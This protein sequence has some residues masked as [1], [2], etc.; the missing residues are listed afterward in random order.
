MIRA[1]SI[2]VLL[3]VAIAPESAGESLNDLSGPTPITISAQALDGFDRADRSRR[4]FGE[5]RFRGGI[6]LSSSH[7][8]FGGLSGFRIQED[9]STFIALSDR[10]V[11]LRGRI[12]YQLGRPAGIT[13]AVIEP[14]LTTG[15][16]PA[17][18]WDTESIAQDGK[19]LYVG[20]EDIDSIM[21]YEYNA[22]VPLSR[23]RKM[24]IPEGLIALPKNRGLEAL[25][26]VPGNLPHGGSLIAFS[27][28]GLDN[29]GN[30][31]AFL[32]GDSVTG[33]FSVKRSDDYDISDAAILRSGEV[34]ILERRFT[35]T[36]LASTRIRRIGL[37]RIRPGAV[38]DGP[39]IFEGDMR[40]QIDNMECIDVHRS[41][42]GEL[43]VTLVSDDNY[44][45][46][47]RTLLLQFT[48]AATDSL[49]K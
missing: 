37:E 41:A 36:G 2:V 15:G 16:R 4:Q 45:V 14:V 46:I 42:S 22:D 25:V 43:I 5:L 47:Q 49:D 9:G 23:A 6:V 39:V 12:V 30:L 21:I 26:F 11:W 18:K 33:E 1:I 35:L 20:V 27:E 7:K 31:K 48:L 8:A 10:G 44:S 28:R 13:D 32:I 29:A 17:F 38:V 24:T 34:L 40:C 3:L 19:K